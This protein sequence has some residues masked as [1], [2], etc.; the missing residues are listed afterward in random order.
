MTHQP[1][2][3]AN[4]T[5]PEAYC[6]G[7]ITPWKLLIVDDDTE[8]HDTTCF[9]LR[10][11]HVLNQPIHFLHAYD[12]QQ[13]QMQ[14]QEH[15]DIALVLLDVVMETEYAGLDLVKHIRH[16]LQL[17]EC[18]IIL[19]TGQP[20]H[21]PQQT[22]INEYDINDYHTKA[23]LTHTRLIT[24]V[25][26]TLRDYQQLRTLTKQRYSMERIVRATNDLMA[27]STI[28]NLAEATLTQL[29]TLF[30]LSPHGI[31]CTYRDV[32]SSNGNSNNTSSL[33]VAA[34]SARYAHYIDQPIEALQNTQIASAILTCLAQGQHLLEADYTVLYL[35]A[36]PGQDIILF[37]D[38]GQ[39]LTTLN[40][41]LLDIFLANIA[42]CFRNIKLV[43]RLLHTQQE[44]ERQR[45]FLKTVI[46]A[47]P[48]CL[49][50]KDRQGRIRLANQG[51]AQY[52]NCTPEQLIGKPFPDSPPAN[53]DLA[54]TLSEG[55]GTIFS[56]EQDKIEREIHFTDRSGQQHWLYTIK[57]AIKNKSNNVE[58]LIGVGIDTTRR[59]QAEEALFE[60]KER[61]QVTLHSI[62]DAVIT[63]D[64][65]G[66]IE[67][68]NPV[69]EAL[70]GWPLAQ[71]QGQVSSE[72][73]HIVHEKNRQPAPDPVAH[74]LRAQTISNLPGRAIL[75]SRNGS[76]CYI[77][78]SVAPIRRR[79]G[80][81]LGTVLVFRDIT[82]T[83]QLVHR[84]E[85]DATHDALTGLVNR[86]ELERRLV[87]A[88]TSTKKYGIQHAL[89]YLDLDQF[90]LINDTA[91]H[92]AGDKLLKQISAILPKIFRERDT[93]ARI[94]GDE[95]GLL[96]EN[97]PLDRAQTIAQTVVT[98]IREYCFSWEG[99]TY[100]VGASIG[101]API[102]TEI[103]DTAQIM[104]QVD[105]ACYIAKELGRNR[106]HLYQ[107]E[108]TETA[109]R[110]SEI[111]G[112]TG[113]RDA[114]EKNRFRLYYQPIVPLH[115]T[116]LRPTHYEALLRVVSK[117]NEDENSELVLPAAFIPA[118]ER[119]G[120]M[121]AIDRWVIRAALRD[122]ADGVGQTKANI[123]INLSGNSLSDETLLDFIE[124]QFI[125]FGFPPESLCLEITETA[126]IQ[127]LRHATHL[128]TALKSYGS[129]FALDDF[130][131]GLSSF[132]YL[133][134]LPVNYL[135]ID[136]SFVKNMIENTRDNA[137][138]AAI[139]Q[140][141]HT[142]GIETVAKYTH[143]Q[144]I[145]ERLR[146]LGVDYAQGYFLG[147]PLPWPQPQT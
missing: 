75:I 76:E 120:L 73:F 97:C 108:D 50:V 10:D 27:Q 86:I 146:E 109:Q 138:V 132:H 35:K 58:H 89:C 82:K 5:A 83:Q 63:T 139:N 47:D 90:K 62:G 85:H 84:L 74:C 98:T 123:A 131:N 30:G 65:R 114:L 115:T 29:N 71:A 15:P 28:A 128:I 144:A 53:I 80:Q 39:T 93:F 101:L 22:I 61:A 40:G 81:L 106:V 9:I 136:G 110:H 104:T 119:Y 77:D 13:A 79:D 147:Q 54:Q 68:I 14:L 78:D 130:G 32:S 21:A 18:R 8:V 72:V 2:S 45:L 117:V 145:L 105:I 133:K 118:A 52:F 135:K 41:Q 88:L 92:T 124:A 59:K 129:Q 51:F 31:I 122:Y 137:L 67:Y 69:A 121:G 60:A 57:A 102:T 24:A 19:R 56:Q 6:C 7:G 107:Y 11:L 87:R 37:L 42:S 16:T 99:R 43:E 48:H 34:A 1:I 100:Q 112:A 103:Q 126:A 12:G 46:D 70:T 66:I 91:G 125:E 26:T 95:F 25:S 134:T 116:D 38:N 4:G 33:Y 36:A 142:L 94:G 20:G 23:D 127:N 140:M 55:D 44:V 113:L 49:Y 141:S 143:S 111:L 64:E 17:E 3:L 96:L